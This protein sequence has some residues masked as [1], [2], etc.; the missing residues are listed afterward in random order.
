MAGNF[1]LFRHAERGP[2]DPPGTLPTSLMASAAEWL[3]K[4][5]L[6]ML[7]K[8]KKHGLNFTSCLWV[9]LNPV[10]F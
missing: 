9:K 10:N 2:P 5:S 3:V 1:R 7:I 8:Q 6:H 4:S